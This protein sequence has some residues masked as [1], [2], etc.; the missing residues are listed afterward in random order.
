M[1]SKALNT[2]I[3][4]EDSPMERSM[5][6]DFFKK[7]K[8]VKV[9]EYPTGNAC[10]KELI[11]GKAEEPDLILMDFFLD[12][13]F[14]P[15]KDGLESLAKLKEVCPNTNVIMFTSVDNKNIIDLCRQKGALDYVVKGP[16]AFEQLDEVLKRH[17]ALKN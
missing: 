17:F 7:F 12:S 15:S 4:V 3:V 2:V 1:K 5:M 8:G 11:L 10:I 6:T 13:S 9:S 16:G 14:G